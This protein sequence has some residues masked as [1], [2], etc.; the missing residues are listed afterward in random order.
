VSATREDRDTVRGTSSRPS[1]S[2][3]VPTRD[4]P[5]LLARALR[6]IVD[7]GYGGDVEVVIVFDRSKVRPVDVEPLPGRAVRS[8]VNTRTPGLAGARNT[9]ILE[10]HGELVAFC[11]D[12]DEWLPDKLTAQ[13]ERLMQRPDASAVATGIIV[14]TQGRAIKRIAPAEV[15]TFD[16]L[17]NSR[18][19]EMHPSTFLARRLDLLDQDGL[20]DEAIPG[21]YGEDYE[22][23]LR[24]ARRGP[25]LAIPRPLARVHWHQASWFTGRW[26]T[27]TEAL[28]YLLERYPE[29][30]T[31]RRGLARLRGQLAFAHAAARRPADARRWAGL[32]LSAN[33][34]ERRAFA[35]L[36]VSTGLVPA[37]RVLDLANRFGRGI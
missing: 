9:G 16:M 19:M 33:P 31:Q 6:S 34:L 17:L 13:V 23:L 21:A 32:A 4:R 36:A 37:Q 35:A 5:E 30:S 1:I 12:D 20:V 26:D 29:F 24:R 7:Q 3:I 18:I 8:L 14:H 2:V 15:I 27:I 28:T 22:W 10:A 11:D 25:V